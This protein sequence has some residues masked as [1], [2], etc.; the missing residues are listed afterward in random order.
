MNAPELISQY[1]TNL[2][3]STGLVP[4][5][6]TS[7]FR[8]G[9]FYNT[10]GVQNW[11]PIWQAG[12]RGGR[13]HAISAYSG[14]GTSPTF[15]L[16]VGNIL[17]PVGCV[18]NVTKNGTNDFITRGAGGSFLTDGWQVGDLCLVVNNGTQL[19]N[20]LQQVKTLTSATVLTLEG[21]NDFSATDAAAINTYL[22]RVTMLTPAISLTTT[23]ATSIL[24]TTNLPFLAGGADNYL[25]LGPNEFLV[26]WFGVQPTAPGA[27]I[28]QQN[29]VWVQGGWY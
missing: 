6:V 17:T 22:L 25:T 5:G 2:G 28:V 9:E 19:N 26:A 8:N 21:V 15:W 3:Q 13:V 10:H 29:Y 12:P 7:I 23:T 11:A 4:M 14:T 24:T 27:T 1:N 16:G 18:A 20:R